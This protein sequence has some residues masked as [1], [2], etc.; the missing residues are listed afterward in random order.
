MAVTVSASAQDAPLIGAD[1]A[2]AWGT[3]PRPIERIRIGMLDGPPEYTFGDVLFLTVRPDGAMFVY[4]HAGPQISQYS[5]DGSYVRPIG[6]VGEGPGEYRSVAGIELLE[7][8]DL[9]V[10]DPGN[11]RLSIYDSTGSFQT[12]HPVRGG[13]W[14]LKAFAVD[15]TGSLYVKVVE[16]DRAASL[17]ATPGRPIR[18][19]IG[20]AQTAGRS[21][22]LKISQ[23]GTT[24]TIPLPPRDQRV[25]PTLSTGDGLRTN[26]Q[27]GTSFAISPLGHLVIGN[28]ETYELTYHLRGRVVR[29]IQRSF[30]HV[31][32]LP[33][34]KEQWD[35]WAEYF[36][37]Q[38]VGGTLARTPNRKP[39]FRDIIVDRDGRIWVNRYVR[40]VEVQTEKDERPSQRV[41]PPYNW[42]EPPTFDVIDSS[43]VFLGT[44]VFPLNTRILWSR[45]SQVWGVARGKFGEQ[46]VV[47]FHI[48]YEA[49]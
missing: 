2:P 17:N 39:A 23:A 15:T 47:G 10:W 25:A 16:V 8:G 40:A 38:N 30:R 18:M 31:Q 13:V 49:R 19:P 4:D 11:A 36:E 22:F 45:E 35:A 29:R 48:A 14:D 37:Q 33:Q 43:G 7:G 1:N 20:S 46:Y 9:V 5:G 44:L 26:F 41:R 24:D 12:S 32:A 28:N 6:R 3:D 21:F 27:P 34:E 42:R